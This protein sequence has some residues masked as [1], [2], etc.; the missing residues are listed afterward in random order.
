MAQTPRENAVRVE[1][2]RA[3]ELVFERTD[4]A[5][6]LPVA[7]ERPVCRKR[8]RNR[9]GNEERGQR[10]DDDDDRKL[11]EIPPDLTLQEADRQEKAH[12]D[13][14]DNEPGHAD[15]LWAL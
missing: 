14:G 6:R 5:P 2:P 11:D 15:L 7:A 4:D 12:V 10:R 9:E 8:R 3:V 13:P 1:R